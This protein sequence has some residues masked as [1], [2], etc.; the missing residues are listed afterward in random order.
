MRT[1]PAC[2]FSLLLLGCSSYD[3]QDARDAEIEL[4]V[5]HLEQRVASLAALKDRVA[6]LEAALGSRPDT[7]TGAQ[8][9]ALEADVRS[10]RQQVRTLATEVGKVLAGASGPAPGPAS[11][12]VAGAPG[13]RA[14]LPEGEPL[15]VLTAGSGAL[16]LVRTRGRLARVRLLGID[17]PLRA[18]QYAADPDRQ[19][20]HLKAFRSEREVDALWKASR[21]HLEALVAGRKVQLRFDSGG[22]CRHADGSVEAYVEVLS[23]EQ[24]EPVADLG[25]AMIRDGHALPLGGHRQADGYQALAEAARKAQAGLLASPPPAPPPAGR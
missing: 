4:K 9:A 19:K 10:L 23:P 20:R 24:G 16:L 1:A 6:V 15:E 18:D 3:E 5:A 8:V 25:A 13:G 2:L 11:A 7:D 17:P 14:T 12:A 22:P 21:D